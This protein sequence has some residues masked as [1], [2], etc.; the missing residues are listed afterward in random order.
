MIT[1]GLLR[2]VFVLDFLIFLRFCNFF[3]DFYAL[4]HK[5][6]KSQIVSKNS[7]LRKI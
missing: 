7:I 2:I 4:F 5:V 6:R 1:G 3:V